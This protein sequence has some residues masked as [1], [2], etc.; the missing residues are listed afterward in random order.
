M[1]LTGSNN[2]DGI[3]GQCNCFVYACLTSSN[4][5]SGFIWHIHLLR[6]CLIQRTRS[7][8]HLFEST[9][10]TLGSTSSSSGQLWS[11]PSQN[12]SQSQSTRFDK[13]TRRFGKNC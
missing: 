9:Q 2:T 6:M 3:S 10:P 4:Q 5:R 13:T 1:K 7:T 11:T 8:Q 12:G